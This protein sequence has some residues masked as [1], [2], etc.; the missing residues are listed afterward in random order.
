M[1]K[2]YMTNIFTKDM[3]KRPQ[4]EEYQLED[5]Q[6]SWELVDWQQFAATSDLEIPE[7][8]EKFWNLF[9]QPE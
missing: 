6:E 5:D 2:E 3:T 7:E 8:Y 9:N 4:G 1:T